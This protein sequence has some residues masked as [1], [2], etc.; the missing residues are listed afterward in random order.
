MYFPLDPLH[1]LRHPSQLYEAFFEGIVLFAILWG[2]RRRSPF[3]G[4]LFASYLFATAWSD[5]SSNFSGA[6]R[7]VG[8][9]LGR[10]LQHGAGSLPSHDGSRR[11]GVYSSQAAEERIAG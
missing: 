7:A 9:D 5:F 4:F 11:S 6:G 8:A 10:S 2:I 1:E 3:D